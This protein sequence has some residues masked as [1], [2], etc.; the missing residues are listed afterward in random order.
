MP[1]FRTEVKARGDGFYNVWQLRPDPMPP[2]EPLDPNYKRW[3][4]TDVVPWTKIECQGKN[5]TG[6]P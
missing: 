6:S 5:F 1:K 4:L 3:V 2:E